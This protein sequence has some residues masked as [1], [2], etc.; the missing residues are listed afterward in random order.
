[1]P[2]Q[3]Q[4]TAK[5]T[6]DT[7]EVED[8]S[9]TT[10]STVDEVFED[11]VTDPVTSTAPTTS[12]DKSSGGGGDPPGSNPLVDGLQQTMTGGEETEQEDSGRTEK[13]TDLGR[14][15]YE[16][17]L[18]KWLGGKLYTAMA[19][20][21]TLAKMQGYAGQA[22][23]GA[24]P[25]LKDALKGLD[26]GKDVDAA[27]LDAFATILLE[28][29]KSG[30]E[31]W[32]GS[33]DGRA[34]EKTA[35]W[36]DK[37]PFW[38][39]TI[40]VAAAAT[41]V[42]TNQDIPELD[43]DN[44]KL[45]KDVSIDFGAKLGKTMDL[46][47]EKIELQIQVAAAKLSSK[48]ERK[49][50]QDE[51]AGTETLTEKGGVGLSVSDTVSVTDDEGVV[52]DKTIERLKA[53][54]DG[55][56]TS[57]GE[58]D[59]EKQLKSYEV[60]A[61]L[62][63]L[64]GDK[65]DESLT[66][67][68][69]EKGT[70]T[71]DGTSREQTGSLSVKDDDSTLTLG[72]SR[73]IGGDGEIDEQTISGSLNE[74]LSEDS[75]LS[76]SGSEKTVTGDDG[77][78]VTTAGKL[79]YKDKL[80]SL[81]LS[82]SKKTDSGE[83]VEQSTSGKLSTSLSP[84]TTASTELTRA[85]K[86]DEESGELVS[87]TTLGGDLRSKNTTK[88]TD[89]EEVVLSDSGISGKIE[90][91]GDDIVLYD[92]KGDFMTLVDRES[93]TSVGGDVGVSKS[94]EAEDPTIKG[95]IILKSGGGTTQTTSVEKTGD[96]IVFKNT[97]K[98][99]TESSSTTFTDESASDGSSATSL[100]VNGKNEDGLG[101]ETSYSKETGPTVDGKPGET[102]ESG[103]G[104]ITYEDDDTKLAVGGKVDGDGGS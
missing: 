22:L 87:S 2:P 15:K 16:A 103:S 19:P 23:E 9:T 67:S 98:S 84:D 92:V 35:G 32:L 24:M 38:I 99:V 47:L 102:T 77:D 50:V 42:L 49:I 57:S 48:Y 86:K 6:T 51:D 93:G 81:D 41:Y 101:I 58:I 60:T 40:A 10:T 85:T 14:E 46:A 54:V 104:K 76:L 7:T 79:A 36:I 91:R 8:T 97:A 56:R 73:K 1:M 68:G 100:A 71:D 26:S 83:L 64:L 63:A 59:G 62:T 61:G 27:K 20:H 66:L 28:K 31:G 65:G 34:V 12:I 37:N 72:G 95:S 89:G 75:S 5:K 55:T 3:I 39:S 30:A 21:L 96:E 69:S 44:I 88:N 90:Q 25:S 11:P 52:S 29:S 74:K 18:G 4:T 45:G 82:T 78:V 53:S 43:F 94:E 80:S 17:L 70:V 13:G 33:E